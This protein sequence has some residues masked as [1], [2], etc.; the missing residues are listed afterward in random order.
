[1]T[2]VKNAEEK[3]TNIQNTTQQKLDVKSELCKDA[4]SNALTN[5]FCN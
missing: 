1:V 3:I 4:S 5:Q 2:F